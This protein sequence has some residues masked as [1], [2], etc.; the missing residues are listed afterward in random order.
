M[1]AALLAARNFTSSGQALEGHDGYMDAASRE[2]DYGEL[3]DKLGGSWEIALNTYKPFA[4]GIVIHPVIDGMLQLR[5]EGLT[6]GEVE[7]ISVRTHP[8]VLKLTGKLEPENKEN[9]ENIFF[10]RP[11]PVMRACGKS[12]FMT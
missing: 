5:R 6:A 3:V 11:V 8:L 4:C 12:R 7:Q 9:G 1:L 10:Q 2:R